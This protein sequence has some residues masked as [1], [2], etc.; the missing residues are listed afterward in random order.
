[1][2]GLA[3]SSVNRAIRIVRPASSFSIRPDT[4]ELCGHGNDRSDDHTATPQNELVWGIIK[5]KPRL[6]RFKSG[7]N[8]VT[9]SSL[10]NVPSYRLLADVEIEVPGVGPV[11]G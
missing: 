8:R 11:V 2:S 1:M 10:T 6:A 7:W 3:D 5:L 9:G 4:W